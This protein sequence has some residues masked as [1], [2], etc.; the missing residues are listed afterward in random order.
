[1]ELLLFFAFSIKQMSKRLSLPLNQQ[2]HSNVAVVRFGKKGK[3]LEIACYKNKVVAFRGGLE[4]SLAEVLQIER[5]FSNVSRGQ[6]ASLEEIQELLGEEFD[7]AKAVLFI[8]K[9]GELQVGSQ[10]RC[11]ENEE[12]L[13]EICTIITEKCVHRETRRPL[14][15]QFVEATVQSQGFSVKLDQPAKKQALQFMRVLIDK[16][17]IP[18]A[19]APMKL[20]CV[21][22]SPAQFLALCEAHDVR[23]EVLS[24]SNEDVVFLLEPDKFRDVDACSKD[25]GGSIQVVETAVMNTS[26]SGGLDSVSAATPAAEQLRE[27][28]PG[29]ICAPAATSTTVSDCHLPTVEQPTKPGGHLN[30]KKRGKKKHAGADGSEESDAAPKNSR[31]RRGKNALS[32]VYPESGSDSTKE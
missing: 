7:E 28:M 11:E 14:P 30:R 8:L 25:A 16:Q 2:R 32:E 29:N 31:N 13:K 20:R 12:L 5:V 15:L 27:E 4:C 17:P 19:R 21:S 26:D 18:I 23:L 24:R 9:N 1:M 10:E 6:Y 3:R 22:S